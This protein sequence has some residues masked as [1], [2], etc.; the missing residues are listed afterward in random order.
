VYTAQSVIIL[1]NLDIKTNRLAV[2][3]GAVQ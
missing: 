3:L 2:D 1:S